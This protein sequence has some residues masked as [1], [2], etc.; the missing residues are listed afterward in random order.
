M[1]NHKVSRRDSVTLMLT[2]TTPMDAAEMAMMRQLGGEDYAELE[3]E[4]VRGDS[5]ADTALRRQSVF[6]IERSQNI[7]DIFIDSYLI[8]L[9]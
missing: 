7:D 9:K 4:L 6:S 3:G 1:T 8:R 2:E 5:P